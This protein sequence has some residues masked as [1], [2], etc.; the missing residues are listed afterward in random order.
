[1]G[2]C[3]S[4][5]DEYKKDN[6]FLNGGR[7]SPTPVDFV[8]DGIFTPIKKVNNSSSTTIIEKPRTK[9]FE[10]GSSKILF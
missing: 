10:T 9:R 1:M 2:N 7:R 4:G 3:G 5:R 6:S 8:P